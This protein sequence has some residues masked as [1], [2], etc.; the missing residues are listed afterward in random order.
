MGGEQ[1]N[2][3]GAEKNTCIFSRKSV[4]VAVYRPLASAESKRLGLWFDSEVSFGST[5]S[6]TEFEKGPSP[7][8][9]D[10]DILTMYT[11]PATRFSS[12]AMV[13]APIN[14]SVTN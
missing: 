13:I 1:I 11:L 9:L 2:H 5:A 4:T 12:N 3:R 10:A 7:T 14:V 6:S 8:S